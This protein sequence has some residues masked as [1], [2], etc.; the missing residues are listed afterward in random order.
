MF[1]GGEARYGWKLT[2]SSRLNAPV[3]PNWSR[4]SVGMPATHGPT[5]IC[6]GNA[7]F[8][9]LVVVMARL[10][11]WVTFGAGRPEELRQNAMLG[12]LQNMESN[13]VQCDAFRKGRGACRHLPTP[14]DVMW[15]ARPRDLTSRFQR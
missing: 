13:N 4:K 12:S 15:H 10:A 9:A 14:G 3:A 11:Y 7:A 2:P 8:S 5:T 6:S 1:S